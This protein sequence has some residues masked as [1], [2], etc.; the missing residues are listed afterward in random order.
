MS[1]DE[2]EEADPEQEAAAQRAAV[3]AAELDGAVVEMET[4]PSSRPAAQQGALLQLSPSSHPASAFLI[5]LVA[6]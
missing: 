4:A 1:D 6:P 2:E 3:T 5:L